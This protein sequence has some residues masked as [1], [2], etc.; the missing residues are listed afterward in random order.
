MV[1]LYGS[2]LM[3]CVCVCWKFAQGVRAATRYLGEVKT[4]FVLD[5]S[6]LVAVRVATRC[7]AWYLSDNNVK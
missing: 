4:N 3:S 7:V 1:E 6:V 2:I 5:T